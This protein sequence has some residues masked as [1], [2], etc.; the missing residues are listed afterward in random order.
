MTTLLL[1]GIFALLVIIR[2]PIAISLAV[3][4]IVVLLV[5]GGIDNLALVP[6]VLYSSVAKFTLLAIPFFVLAG[7]IMDYAGISKRLIHFADVCVGHLKGGMIFVTVI[8]A[9]F[10]AA[11]SGSGP[12]TV[13]AIGSILIPALV[14]NGMKRESASALLAS[15]GSIGIV[16]PPSIA[17]IVFAVV[18][19]DQ[20]SISIGR[21]FVAGIIP[22]LLMGIGFIIS[23]LYVKNRGLVRQSIG[24]EE[25]A[26]TLEKRERASGKEVFK[27]FRSA[28][29]GLLIPVIILGGIYGGI[30]TPTEAAVVAVFYGFIVGIFIYRELS[31]KDIF[32][33]LYDASIQTAVITFIVSAASLFAYIIT[34]EQIAQTMSDSLLGLSSSPIVSLLIIN[35]IL[36]IAGAFIDAISAFYIFVPILIPV[37]IHFNIDPTVFGVFM[38]VNLAIGLFTPPVGLNLYVASGIGNVKIH[39]ISKAIVPFLISAVIV[40]LLITYIPALS[41]FLPNLMGIK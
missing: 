40:L 41:T 11:I 34:T 3:S 4:S 33:I 37:I 35:V 38:T 19:G 12:A 24:N 9:I 16:I 2:I 7:V 30:F 36:L 21:L 6:D 15:S 26:A 14:K 13:A 8:T 17:F 27:A 18:A 39:K 22:G 1:F 25:V 20:I 23:A 32:K 10:F 5:S 31:I 29:W 28:I